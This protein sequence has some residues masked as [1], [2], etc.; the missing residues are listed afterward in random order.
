MSTERV[1]TM[2]DYYDGPRGGIA[3][4]RGMPHLYDSL[5]SESMQHN[6]DAFLIMPID[7]AIFEL[8]LEDWRIWRRW[9]KAHKEGLVTVDSHPALPEE[10]ARH[11]ELTK[12]LSGKLK[13]LPDLAIVVPGTLSFNSPSEGDE[14]YGMTVQ[15]GQPIE[16]PEHLTASSEYWRAEDEEE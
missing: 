2:T 15:W 8:A 11:E 12:L 5:W 16:R 6:S 4:Y 14:C 9:E 13:V 3:D 7:E 1:H 10:R